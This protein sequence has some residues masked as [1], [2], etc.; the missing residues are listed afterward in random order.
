M[1]DQ[2]NKKDSLKDK[3]AD[4]A[5]EGISFIKSRAVN[6][7]GQKNYAPMFRRRFYL[8][9]EYEQVIL[10]VCGLGIGYY[11]LNGKKVSEDLF[12]APLSDYNKTLWYNEYDVTN[13]V[14]K[15]GNIFA[16]ILGN[17]WYNETI[18][19]VWDFDRALWRDTPKMIVKLTADGETVLTSDEKFKVTIDSPVIFNQLRSGEH[20]DARLYD[21]QWNTWDYNDEAW[22]A[23]LRDT[24]PPKGIF[25]RCECEP[26]QEEG[27]Y[28]AQTVRKVGDKKYLFDIGQN[29]SGYI[30]LR[31][32]QRSGDVLKIRYAEQI[33]E[34]GSLRLNN[35]ET[36]YPESEFQTDFFV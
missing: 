33:E 21:S 25:R 16:A 4:T 11:Y 31:V 15:G 24:T 13:M 5:F 36:H 10:S 28:P 18:P 7:D 34:D 26:I 9:K 17:G 2:E 30:R 20:F 29:I 35:M 14:N 8:E 1:N 19:S 22:D 27:I 3:Q 12:T 32:R 23:A 6:T